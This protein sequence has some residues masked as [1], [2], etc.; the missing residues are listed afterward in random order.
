MEA[1]PSR[2]GCKVSLS[3]S[4]TDHRLSGEELEL[5]LERKHQ[6]W[7]ELRETRSLRMIGPA[8]K[9]GVIFEDDQPLVYLFEFPA[10]PG[11]MS[12]IAIKEPE[13]VDKRKDELYEIGEALRKRWFKELGYKRVEARVPEGFIQTS[14]VLRRFGFRQE[15]GPSGLRGIVRKNGEPVNIH[16]FGLLPSDRVEKPSDK[17]IQDGVTN[18]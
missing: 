5:L 6:F 18:A 2:K 1:G 14:R 7:D 4:Y 16:V 13:R 3:I 15:T 11:N 17:I 10:E 8:C 9:F 12:L